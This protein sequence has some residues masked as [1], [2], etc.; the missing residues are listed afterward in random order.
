MKPILLAGGGIALLCAGLA[1]PAAHAQSLTDEERQYVNFIEHEEFAKANF[2]VDQGLVDPMNLSSGKPL[3]YYFYPGP[4]CD[5]PTGGNC[6][7]SLVVAQ[8]LASGFDLNAPVRD[9]KRPASYICWGEDGALLTSQYANDEGWDL[10]FTDDDGLAPLH[11]CFNHRPYKRGNDR[12]E[13]LRSIMANLVRGGADVN[14][15]TNKQYGYINA[16]AT[17]LMFAVAAWGG[18]DPYPVFVE[19]LFENGADAAMLD[20]TGANAA[21]YVEY[22]ERDEHYARVAEF[23]RYLHRQGV[24]IMHKNPE[25]GLSMF[26]QAMKKGDVEFAMELME[27]SKG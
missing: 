27:I 4:V 1:N 12:V 15:R 11:Y 13:R 23:M 7:P 19:F 17:P 14:A 18:F 10:N 26:D 9:G 5:G 20:A 3:P 24:D 22:P 16:G 8:F 6:G 2:Y 21:N 25:T